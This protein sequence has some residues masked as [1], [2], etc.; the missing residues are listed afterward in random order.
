[1]K[2]PKLPLNSYYFQVHLTIRTSYEQK[3]GN[4]PI[5]IANYK[6]L[7]P[8]QEFLILFCRFGG[9]KDLRGLS[10]FGVEVEALVVQQVSLQITINPFCLHHHL[11]NKRMIQW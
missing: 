6:I 5:P 10:S 2:L 11:S 9:I 3:T 1:M 8:D 7:F 4:V